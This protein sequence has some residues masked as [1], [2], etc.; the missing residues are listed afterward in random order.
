M[1]SY[2]SPLIFLRYLKKRFCQFL[3]WVQN[4][5]NIP[6]QSINND[7]LDYDQLDYD[8]LDYDNASESC[9]CRTLNCGI[10]ISVCVLGHTKIV[11]TKRIFHGLINVSFRS[12]NVVRQLITDLNSCFPLS[13]VSQNSSRKNL[14]DV[15]KVNFSI[16][17][18]I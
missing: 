17:T 8:E 7:E 12:K 3:Q 18:A 15:E 11:Q 9:A 6:S 10:P 2:L 5:R 4:C 16:K 13:Q 14:N 1:F